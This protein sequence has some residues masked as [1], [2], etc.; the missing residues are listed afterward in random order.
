M[1]TSYGPL[2]DEVMRRIAALD[3]AQDEYEVRLDGDSEEECAA[4]DALDAAR[5]ALDV[6]IEAYLDSD[7]E[8]E[9]AVRAADG[10]DTEIV[11]APAGVKGEAEAW[12]RDGE[13]G[14]HDDDAETCWV[15]V[16]WSPVIAER[17]DGGRDW[18]ASATVTID[19]DEPECDHPDGQHDWQTP[20]D[21]VGGCESNPGCWGHGGGVRGIEVCMY[22]GCGRHT[23]GWAQNP[24]TGEQGLDSVSYTQ[25]EYADEVGRIQR[26]ELC[27]AVEAIVGE[28]A[29]GETDDIRVAVD[30]AI[31]RDDPYPDAE[32][33]ARSVREARENAGK[34]E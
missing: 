21:I 13:Y 14:Q 12:I 8:R 32:T 10:G 4:E 33:I 34:S 16:C 17:Y 27:D 11:C 30:D 20:H 5:H 23:D 19:P 31:T 6:A 7:E 2:H 24:E 26:R 25:G 18:A 22:C 1:S 15:R 29:D 28:D 3:A 9:Y